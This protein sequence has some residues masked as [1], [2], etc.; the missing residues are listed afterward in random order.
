MLIVLVGKDKVCAAAYPSFLSMKRQE[1]ITTPTSM[2]CQSITRLPPPPPVGT[3]LYSWVERGTVS[4][5]CFAQE[6][7]TMNDSAQ[8]W[9]WSTWHGL[10]HTIGGPSSRCEMII[11]QNKSHS[12]IITVYIEIFTTWL[13]GIK[14]TV[15][16][17]IKN[18][19]TSTVYLLLSNCFLCWKKPILVR[20][21]FI[22]LLCT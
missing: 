21:P 4:V 15:K 20:Y 10:P 6:H 22:G 12:V 14:N 9:A 7:N 5:T 11:L 8:S 18:T 16:F 2:G 13:L 17:S 3:H 19:S 1:S